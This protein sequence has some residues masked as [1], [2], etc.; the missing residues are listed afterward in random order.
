MKCYFQGQFWYLND[1]ISQGM[2]YSEIV[3]SKLQNHKIL[4][5]KGPL[6]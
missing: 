1:L 5:Y 6:E 2:Y 3:I 4:E